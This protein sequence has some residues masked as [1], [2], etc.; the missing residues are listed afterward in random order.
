MALTT[1]I[2]QCQ[3][4]VHALLHNI[5]F[6]EPPVATV[7]LDVAGA[8]RRDATNALYISMVDDDDTVFDGGVFAA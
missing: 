2:S 5:P 4:R 6:S 1:A 8:E 3:L 7:S